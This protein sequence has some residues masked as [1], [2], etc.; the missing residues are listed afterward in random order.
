VPSSVHL[1]LYSDLRPC[2]QNVFRSCSCFPTCCFL[3]GSYKEP[4]IR[5]GLGAG[6]A[7]FGKQTE[8][9]RADHLGHL[10]KADGSW[11]IE[12][13]AGSN[14]SGAC[15]VS[16]GKGKP[17]A[18]SH[19]ASEAGAYLM[20]CDCRLSDRLA[21]SSVRTIMQGSIPY[22]Q[23]LWGFELIQTYL[24]NPSDPGLPKTDGIFFL[25]LTCWTGKGRTWALHAPSTQLYQPLHD[26]QSISPSPDPSAQ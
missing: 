17:V 19:M 13:L 10:P 5:P 3:G 16:I 4:G 24:K 8:A 14:S 25:C 20:Q 21:L 7:L 12:R 18:T 26:N 11:L 23:K 22:R 15:E 6:E 9:H 1:R 2:L